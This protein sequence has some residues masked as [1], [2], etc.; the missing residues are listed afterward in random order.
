MATA[1]FGVMLLMLGRTSLSPLIDLRK[2]LKKRMVSA[3]G[4]AE[5]GKLLV[6]SGGQLRSYEILVVR[7]RSGEGR[8]IDALQ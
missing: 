2:A 6:G 5:K 7:R 8:G 1:D 3:W 4:W